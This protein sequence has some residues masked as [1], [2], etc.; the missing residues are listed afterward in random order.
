M[1]T[2][3]GAQDERYRQLDDVA[4]EGKVLEVRDELLHRRSSQ[5]RLAAD[6]PRHAELSHNAQTGTRFEQKVHP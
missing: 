5:V 6:T 4:L 3:G 2:A 1:T